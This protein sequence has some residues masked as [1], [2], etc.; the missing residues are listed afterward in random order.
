MELWFYKNVL[1]VHWTLGCLSLHRAFEL[2]DE[3]G[4]QQAV[5][6]PPP[7]ILEAPMCWVTLWRWGNTCLPSCS[8]TTASGSQSVLPVE[9]V[10]VGLRTHQDR[11]PWTV[12]YMADSDFN[13]PGGVTWP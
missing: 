7:Q 4:S 6:A 10:S 8:Q 3:A 13:Q 5:A 11:S 1:G 9:G 2:V 12:L